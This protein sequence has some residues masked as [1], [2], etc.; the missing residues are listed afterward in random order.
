MDESKPQIHLSESQELKGPIELEVMSRAP[1]ELVW[2]GKSSPKPL[3][4]TPSFSTDLIGGR[5]KNIVYLA[6]NWQALSNLCFEFKGVFQLIYIDPP[7]DSQSNYKM[8]ISMRTADPKHSV[9]STK[10]LQYTDRWDV[11]TYC[12]YLYERLIVARELLNDTG[13]LALHCDG[14]RAHQIR[15]I[16]DEV[17]GPEHF[18]NELIWAYKSGG[19]SSK[20]F[21]RKHDNIYLYAKTDQYRLNIPKQ[22]SYVQRSGNK[23]V[24]YHTDEQGTYTL[25]QARDVWNDI[26][27][28]STAQG[29]RSGYPTEKPRALL[30]RIIEATTQENDWVLD[31]F[32]GSGTTVVEAMSLNRCFVGVD[33]N[34]MAI[35]VCT[36]RLL[37]DEP[38][39]SVEIRY[40]NPLDL[41]EGF[42]WWIL[43][44]WLYVDAFLPEDLLSA[45]NLE[46]KD[47]TE[48]G[49]KYHWLQLVSRIAIDWDYSE[50]IFKSQTLDLPKKGLVKGRY[51]VP[52]KY[53]RIEVRL[54]DISSV[55]WKGR[56][57]QKTLNLAIADR[58]SSD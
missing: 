33:K 57:K 37:A 15:Q 17:F 30:K 20:H 28:L 58:G 50:S 31:F 18:V 2:S 29:I 21:S 45:F 41:K 47:F 14:H 39:S 56:Q 3:S 22:K 38:G 8:K 25:V 12:Q 6:D 44:G 32:L 46:K 13:V 27:M 42:E 1:V 24:T 49:A 35:D 54:T 53:G 26:G 7:F 51:R 9:L 11:S 5:R 36:R 40:L 16:L 52:E 4:Y 23:K 43:D 19:A 48:E 55:C 34:P 10:M